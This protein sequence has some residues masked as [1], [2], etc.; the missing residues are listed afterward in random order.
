M[1]RVSSILTG[2]LSFMSSCGERTAGS[3]EA[4]TGE[5]IRLAEASLAA[6][7]GIKKVK[8][9]FGDAISS[10]EKERLSSHGSNGSGT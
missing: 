5:R 1:W 7:K 4:T 9:L 8:E 2:L 10:I 3:I 6:T